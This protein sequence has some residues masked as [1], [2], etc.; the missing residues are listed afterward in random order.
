M[1]YVRSSNSRF[2]FVKYDGEFYFVPVDEKIPTHI[3]Y[4]IDSFECD[5]CGS[6]E[7]NFTLGKA[8]LI[9][10]APIKAMRAEDHICFYCGAGY[11]PKFLKVKP[12]WV[13]IS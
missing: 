7:F 12:K 6:K 3:A 13:Y 2:Y 1:K 10:S 9:D 8:I 11:E 4:V 5:I